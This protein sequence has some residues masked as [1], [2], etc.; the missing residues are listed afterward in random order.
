ML[1]ARKQAVDSSLAAETCLATRRDSHEAL[2]MKGT[3]DCLMVSMTYGC[4]ITEAEIIVEGRGSIGTCKCLKVAETVIHVLGVAISA[5]RLIW[6]DSFNSQCF[7]A[8]IGDSQVLWGAN[9]HE[10]YATH[11]TIRHGLFSYQEVAGER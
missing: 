9:L 10:M 3:A 1:S 11:I 4:D 6:I 7:K 8:E 2:A 5:A